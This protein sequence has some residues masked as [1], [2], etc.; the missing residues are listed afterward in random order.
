MKPIYIL[1]LLAIQL[2]TLPARAGGE[3]TAA[4]L[5]AQ[6]DAAFSRGLF[7]EALKKFSYAMEKAQ[8]EGDDTTY[9]RSVGNISIIYSLYDDV[10]R[11][12]HY[13]EKAFD[14]AVKTN[15]HTLQS[16][17]AINMVGMCCELKDLKKAQHYYALEEKLA[18]QDK[19]QTVANYYLLYN[20]GMIA[21]LKGDFT[22]ALRQHE[23]ALKFAEKYKMGPRF[24]MGQY[25]E[26]GKC[27]L[28]LHDFSRALDY[29]RRT[30]KVSR[31]V[32]EDNNTR[33]LAYKQMADIYTS[34][35]VPDSAN[36]YNALRVQSTDSVLDMK[37]F[38]KA[39][40]VL[41]RYEQQENDRRNRRNSFMAAVAVLFVALLTFV[42]VRIASHRKMRLQREAHQREL[43][44]L[45]A[46]HKKELMAGQMTR[47][48]NNER[49]PIGLSS[50]QVDLLCD[51]IEVVMRQTDL[52][53]SPDFSLKILAE[54][55]KSNTKYVSWVI[56][57]KFGM[58][59]RQLLNHY[60]IDEAARRLNDIDGEYA[61]YTIEAVAHSVGF[62]SPSSFIE[63]FKSIKGVTPRRYKQGAARD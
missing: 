36:Y 30:L 14:Y 9:I 32:P 22:F 52:I 38:S 33:I 6:G 3:P 39:K 5:K 54:K 50:S 29:T 27:G 44:T 28:H 2:L 4:E 11:S 58:S 34:M 7:T 24:A 63:A 19:S 56:N 16:R 12:L 49:T 45:E 15:D 17:S 61:K 41:M 46:E 18:P 1:L 23:A 26:I 55:V 47:P 59:F 51:R 37:E 35:K 13:I 8:D 31:F 62:N 10:E 57:E 60:R 20:K 25:L 42:I 43:A 48:G 53:T 40:E 21:Q